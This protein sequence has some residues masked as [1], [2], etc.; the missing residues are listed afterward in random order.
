MK[1]VRYYIILFLLLSI[2]LSFSDE[3]KNNFS[4]WNPDVRTGDERLILKT[5]GK[6]NIKSIFNAPAAGSFFMIRA[7]QIFISP[8]DGPNC[9][10]RPTCSAYGKAAVIKY[11]AFLGAMLAGD[12][13]IRCN[14]FTPPGDDPVPDSVFHWYYYSDKKL[15]V[16]LCSENLIP[17][18]NLNL[19]YRFSYLQCSF[20]YHFPVYLLN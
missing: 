1:S 2:Q 17:F 7:F 11:G 12:R 20:S 3:M 16:L 15:P 5:P 13:L 18:Q 4:P 19:F 9:R 8:Q 10:F 6:N 14:P